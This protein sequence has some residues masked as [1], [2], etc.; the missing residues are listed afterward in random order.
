MGNACG[1]NENRDQLVGESKDGAKNMN[2][3][4]EFE[5]E[6]NRNEDHHPSESFA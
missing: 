1:C 3:E 4:K 6:E 2:M 5:D